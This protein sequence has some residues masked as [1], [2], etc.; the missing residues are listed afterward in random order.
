MSGWLQRLLGRNLPGHEARIEHSYDEQLSVA[1]GL[2]KAGDC[3]AAEAVYREVI[4]Q[5]GNS[6]VASRLLGK[7]L[8]KNGRP[9]EAVAVL[10]KAHALCPEDADL[11]CD[12]CNAH[13][14]QG[15]LQQ[16]EQCYRK[17]LEV[18][19]SHPRLH[20]NLGMTLLDLGDKKS[21]IREIEAT[22]VSEPSF[23]LAKRQL[24]L[25]LFEQGEKDKA[26]PMMESLLDEDEGDAILHY[27]LGLHAYRENNYGKAIRHFQR[28]TTLYDKH[29]ESFLYLGLCLD[30]T[31]DKTGAIQA[32]EKALVIDQNYPDGILGLGA[33]YLAAGKNEPAEKKF[34]EAMEANLEDAVIACRIGDLYLERQLFTSAAIYYSKA[35]SIDPDYAAAYINI[36]ACYQ[37][38]GSNDQAMRSYEKALDIDPES[39]EAHYNHA[40]TLLYRGMLTEGWKEY[41]WGLKTFERKIRKSNIRRWKNE[42]IQNCKLLVRTEQGVGDE[43]MFASCI[44]DLINVSGHIFVECDHRLSGLFERSFKAVTIIGITRKTPP[45]WGREHSFDFEVPIGSLPMYLRPDIE[46]FPNHH[47]YLV[48]DEHEKAHWQQ[49]L[50]L[51]GAG[52]KIGIAWRSRLSAGS[53]GGHYTRLTD[54]APIL[55]T[56]GVHFVNLQYDDCTDELAEAYRSCGVRITDFTDLDQ[57]NDIDGVAAL[58]G[59]LDLVITVGTS[60]AELAG[61][62]GRPV[63]KMLR[64]RSWPMLGTDR[65]PWYPATRVFIP[66]A[67]DDDWSGVIKRIGALLNDYVAHWRL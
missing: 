30:K 66:E 5:H 34:Q 11:Y 32:I 35:I 50:S 57:F 31:N 37:E 65:S 58:M 62:L 8:A 3:D 21:A 18:D 49:R 41:E 20:F 27:C 4:R 43:I 53:R 13:R 6:V 9:D 26:V 60:V 42:D 1:M 23:R 61:A 36:G 64:K 44:P 12:L 47:G 2:E 52:P 16:A 28:S 45:L 63:W 24:S 19:S 51:L 55:K 15:D 14:L 22:V 38:L 29:K 17:A 33:V 39:K 56:P 48:A 10:A 25:L 54:W 40:F 59:T 46:S 7:L 67:S